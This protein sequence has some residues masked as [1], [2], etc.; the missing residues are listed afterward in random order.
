MEALAY[1]Q[2]VELTE[3]QEIKT[4]VVKSNK[5]TH[6]LKLAT[7][8]RTGKRFIKHARFADLITDEN[9]TAYS[10]VTRLSVVSRN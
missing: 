6:S 7:Y 9:R 10:P 4:I 5:G 3:R 2:K 1:T 8:K